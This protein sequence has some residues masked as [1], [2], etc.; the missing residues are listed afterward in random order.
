MRGYDP[1]ALAN[2]GVLGGRTKIYELIN[3]GLLRA[4]KVGRRTVI[5]EQD[6]EKCLALLPEMPA[7]ADTASAQSHPNTSEKTAPGSQR[8]RATHSPTH[9]KRRRLD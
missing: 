9:P 1:K 5:L 3:A 6:V 8:Q 4:V 2:T 7:K